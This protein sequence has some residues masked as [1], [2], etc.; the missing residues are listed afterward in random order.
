MWYGLLRFAYAWATLCPRGGGTVSTEPFLIIVKH[1][2]FLDTR[3]TCT[4]AALPV[5]A[6]WHVTGTDR[7]QDGVSIRVVQHAFAHAAVDTRRTCS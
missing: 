4:F 3:E 6:I 2:H 7:S 1:I 5:F